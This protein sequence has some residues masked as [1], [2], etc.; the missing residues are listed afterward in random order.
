MSN[1]IIKKVQFDH[2]ASIQLCRYGSMKNVTLLP[3][4]HG[5]KKS[6]R[7]I[8]DEH[9]NKANTKFLEAMARESKKRSQHLALFEWDKDKH[10]VLANLESR[11]HPKMIVLHKQ[12]DND[13]ANIVL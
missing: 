8:L 11:K 5:Q 6:C 4:A 1:M 7:N 13:M 12:V 3:D 10:A 2:V 9:F